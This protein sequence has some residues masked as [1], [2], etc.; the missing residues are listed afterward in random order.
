MVGDL[1]GLV[2]R[3]ALALAEAM[4]GVSERYPDVH[5]SV[6]TATGGSRAGRRP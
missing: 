5:A 2:E 3:D 4:A 1:Y 6:R